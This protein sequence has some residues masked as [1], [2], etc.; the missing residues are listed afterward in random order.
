MRHYSNSQVVKLTTILLFFF[1]FTLNSIVSAQCAIPAPIGSCSGENGS[2]SNG[3]NLNSGNV[4]WYSGTGTFNSGI[5]LNGGTLRVCGNLTLNS[6]SANSGSIH[7]E[8]GGVLTINSNNDVYFN[9]GLTIVNRGILTI[10]SNV[11]LQNSNNYIFNE[12]GATLNMNSGN[13]RLEL[14]S[15]SSFF[16]NNGTA[17]IHELLIQ[18]NTATG[19]V[20]LGSGSCLNLTNLE[21]NRINSVR[22]L[23]SQANIFYTNEATLNDDLTNTS[24]VV[25]CKGANSYISGG[26]TFGNAIVV[27]NCIEC[28]AVLPVELVS[29][30][31]ERKEEIVTLEWTTLSER[32]N[33][34]FIVERSML[35]D[36]WESVS[37]VNGK[38]NT[39]EISDYKIK[40]INTE[41]EI[42]YYRISQVDFDGTT[43]L[44]KELS[45]P[46]LAN[47][48]MLVY[49]N[50][51]ID[52][53]SLYSKDQGQLVIVDALGR[54]VSELNVQAGKNNYDLSH[55]TEG[56]YLANYKS[57]NDEVKVLILV[58][59]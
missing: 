50:P 28:A 31:A 53:L 5:I 21:N 52:E 46:G 38:G 59:N 47:S 40:D 24:N 34:F 17:N 26:Q 27:S 1:S 37:I 58:K 41:S 32:N 30:T 15:S 23:T 8:P 4:Y 45:V 14:N 2:A 16:I 39:T 19:C 49:P 13:Q 10:H 6:I 57:I 36:D 35:M 7:V 33:D 25:V 12:L 56:T 20:C 3:Q 48:S 43:K 22:A 29:F 11:V 44:I 42:S 54:I 9:G 18:T 55:L 51:F